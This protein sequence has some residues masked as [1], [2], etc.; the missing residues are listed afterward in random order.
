MR[1]VPIGS[2]WK[3]G[4]FYGLC[5][6]VRL[7]ADERQQMAF[8]GERFREGGNAEQFTFLRPVDDR[9]QTDALRRRNAAFL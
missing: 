3:I 2:T 1:L 5:V 7:S 8:R 6:G 9:R 4:I